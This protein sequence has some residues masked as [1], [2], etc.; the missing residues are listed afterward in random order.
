MIRRR[1]TVIGFTSIILALAGLTG[2]GSDTA[3][4][5][6]P[7]AAVQQRASEPQRQRVLAP[8]DGVEMQVRESDPPQYIVSIASGLPNGCAAFDDIAVERGDR[9]LAIRVWNTIPA[10]PHVICT[11]IYG[12]TNNIVELG[13]EFTPGERYAIHI[14]GETAFEFT[15][16]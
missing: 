16:Q 4:P 1:S 10:D 13:D 9:I 2:C 8:I 15:A 11:M 6:P 14:N 3:E 7:S 12:L 5:D